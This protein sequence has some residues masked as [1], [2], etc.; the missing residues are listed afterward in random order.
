ML[1][2]PAILAMT[3]LA[4]TELAEDATQKG[5]GG[6]PASGLP[7]GQPANSE[8]SDR[9]PEKPTTSAG[10]E[11]ERSTPSSPETKTPRAPDELKR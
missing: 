6:T 8:T 4:G 2:L 5:P 10:S 9:S 7:P 3:L 11:K 1:K